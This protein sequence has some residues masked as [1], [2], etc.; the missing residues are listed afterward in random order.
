MARIWPFKAKVKEQ[1]KEFW[2]A[3]VP[4]QEHYGLQAL[5]VDEAHHQTEHGDGTYGLT[6]DILACDALVIGTADYEFKIPD[7]LPEQRINMIQVLANNGL[8]SLVWIPGLLAY[9]LSPETLS[10]MRDAPPFSGFKAGQRVLLAIGY[11]WRPK[12][13]PHTLSF[14]PFWCGIIDVHAS[15]S[16]DKQPKI[17][18]RVV[19]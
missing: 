12:Q 18:G 13:Q 2:E 16:P 3:Y 17:L 7:G 10:P 11:A 1:T 4:T 19:E 15:L 14:C 9:V 6:Y 8:Y 5:T